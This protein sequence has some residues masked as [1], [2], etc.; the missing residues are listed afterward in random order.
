MGLLGSLFGSNKSSSTTT[1]STTNNYDQRQVNDAGGGVIGQGNNLDNSLSYASFT[2]SRSTTT[3]V[4][5]D[6]GAFDVVRSVADGITRIGVDQVAAARDIAL[7]ADT[8]SSGA[9]DFARQAQQSAAGFN[10][11]A[12]SKAFDLA[13]SSST[14]AFESSGAA[15]GFTRD[16]FSDVVSLA[17][18][19]IGQAG[20]QA[21]TVATTAG[22]AYASASDTSSGNKTL[23]YAGIAAVAL[24]GV[25]AAFGFMKR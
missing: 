17:K 2:D 24:V 1:Q 15:L 14:Q 8:Q 22:A 23:L 7:R 13:R 9:M 12:A 6:G 11:L 4:S 3:N 19:V 10:E 18:D 5:T 16:T 21:K 20:D 25:V